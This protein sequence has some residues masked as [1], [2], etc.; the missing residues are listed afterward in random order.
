MGTKDLWRIVLMV[1]TIGNAV[2][3]VANSSESAII[4]KKFIAFG[5]EFG[6]A[7]VSNLLAVAD[8]LDATALDGVG[9]NLNFRRND[10]RWVNFS[11]SFMHEPALQWD[12]ISPLVQTFGK[13]VSHRSMKESFILMFCS[14]TNR[15]DWADDDAW[16][17][18]SINLRV[19]ARLA[20]RS[21]LRGICLDD[22]DYRRQGQFVRK[23]GDLPIRPLTALVRRRAREVF[24]PVF[25]EYPDMAM[26]LFR[27]FTAGKAYPGSGDPLA[28][29]VT[30]GDLWPWFLNG[31]LDVLPPMAKLIDGYEDSY[32][33]DALREDYLKGYVVSRFRLANMADGAEN[34]RKYRMQVSSSMAIFL[35]MYGRKEGSSYYSPPYNGTRFGHLAANLSQLS[36]AADEYVW[37]WGESRTWVDWRAYGRNFV[38]KG[39][40]QEAYG[41]IVE[42]IE[43]L[44]DPNGYALRKLK[45]LKRAGAFR[46]ANPNS[47]CEMPAG[48]MPDVLT[49]PY[50]SWAEKKNGR[51]NRFYFDT[52][53]GEGDRSSICA[54]D[55]QGCVMLNASGLHAGEIYLVGFSVKGAPACGTLYWKRREKWDFLTLPGVAISVSEADENGWCHAVTTVAVPVGADGFG[56]QLV[57]MQAKGEKSWFDNVFYHKA[58]GTPSVSR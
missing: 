19:V 27:F 24:S 20:K 39:L 7:S 34:R 28:T 11:E 53:T 16:K 38:S 5:W 14:P 23:A 48:G 51:K 21:S 35:D 57:P 58:A 4:G 47:C 54:E 52:T 56:L 13:L 1:L 43:A 2:F 17:R 45:S 3:A 9:I 36:F 37:F 18:L 49:A 44:K 33:F 29:S 8:E 32:E 31:I 41:G 46:P 6:G 15:L 12:E 25:E 42:M 10:G 55:V 22:E 50:S 30:R 26:F 40:W